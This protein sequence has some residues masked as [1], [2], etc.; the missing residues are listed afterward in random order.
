M[1]S[2]DFS[3]WK[4]RWKLEI[5]GHSSFW[6]LHQK[7]REELKLRW[8]R[9]VPFSDELFDRW[10]RARFLGFG[11]GASIYDSSLVLGDVKVGDNTWIG[12]FTVLDGRGGLRIGK[13]CSISCGVQIYSHDTVKWTLS[14]G[15]VSEEHSLTQIGDCT[16]IGASSIINR[17][18]TVGD[19]CVIGAN[20][21]VKYDVPPFTVVG[22]SPAK[23][24]G[25][26]AL[27]SGE[28][29]ELIYD[30]AST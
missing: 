11:D 22:G 8:Q 26:V 4:D 25:R 19:H 3:S 16:Y 18:V 13:F 23:K 2:D 12:P 30:S 1:V 6:Q 15:K 7:L 20:S 28:Q 9:A 14:A 29:V 10:E 27:M 24:I 21:F 5:N 17:G